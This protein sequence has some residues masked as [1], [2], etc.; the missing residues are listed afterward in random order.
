MMK[1]RILFVIIAVAIAVFTTSCR[2]RWSC[3]KRYVNTK[4]YNFKQHHMLKN[5]DKMM[6]EKYGKKINP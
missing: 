2:S 4:P 6:L 3:K 1:K 5:Y